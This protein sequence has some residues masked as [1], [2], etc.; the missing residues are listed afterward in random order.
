MWQEA[1]KQGDYFNLAVVF[2]V[3][4]LLISFFFNVC[5][6]TQIEKILRGIMVDYKRR[7]ERRKGFYDK[8]VT[9]SLSIANI[10]FSNTKSCVCSLL[11]KRP[12]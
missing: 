1:R 7:A 5:A 2:L 8:I 6:V 10:F 3:E 9:A 11:E 4:F 12:S